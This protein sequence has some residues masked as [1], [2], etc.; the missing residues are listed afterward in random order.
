MASHREEDHSSRS[1]SSDSLADGKRHGTMAQGITLHSKKLDRLS[2][3]VASLKNWSAF[4]KF[5]KL[6]MI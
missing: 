5:V 1:Q 4:K 2:K 6:M 3:N